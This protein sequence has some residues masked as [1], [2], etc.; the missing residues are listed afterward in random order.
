MSHVHAYLCTCLCLHLHLYL[1]LLLHLLLQQ[2]TA[3]DPKALLDRHPAEFVA[4]VS[5]MCEQRGLDQHA[6]DK[7]GLSCLRFTDRATHE[8]AVLA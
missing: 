2:V 8:A 7:V 4:L 6:R 1:H 3:L 5:A